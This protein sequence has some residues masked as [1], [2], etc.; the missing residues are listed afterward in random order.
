MCPQAR[1]SSVLLHGPL[2]SLRSHSAAALALA[3]AAGPPPG[4]HR[5]PH[6]GSMQQQQQQQQQHDFHAAAATVGASPTHEQQPDQDGAA[7]SAGSGSN[8]TGGL[9]R[10]AM[11]ALPVPPG[12]GS[13]EGEEGEEEAWEMRRDGWQDGSRLARSL[14]AGALSSSDHGNVDG[15]SCGGD[16]GG[17][18]GASSSSSGGG[19]AAADGGVASK[20]ARKP[21]VGPD[22]PDVRAL[23][24]KAGSSS[25]GS[26][27]SR[28]WAAA[29]APPLPS[30]SPSPS[31]IHTHNL[32]HLYHSSRAPGHPGPGRT[33]TS[34][35]SSSSGSGKEHIYGLEMSGPHMTWSVLAWAFA[36]SNFHQHRLYDRLALAVLLGLDDQGRSSTT[37]ITAALATS[38]SA[39]STGA[40]SAFSAGSAHGGG[41]HSNQSSDRPSRE[42]GQQQTPTAQASLTQVIRPQPVLTSPRMFEH[43]RPPPPPPPLPAAAPGT[44]ALRALSNP[45]LV[46]LLWAYAAHDHRPGALLQV[47]CR[48]VGGRH[49]AAACSAGAYRLRGRQSEL[50]DYGRSVGKGMPNYGCGIGGGAALSWQRRRT[51]YPCL[52]YVLLWRVCGSASVCCNRGEG[53]LCCVPGEHKQGSRQD[54][55]QP[56]IECT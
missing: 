19:G 12:W 41:H 17:E 36:R 22:T 50:P 7:A 8:V 53:S 20:P 15:G 14:A 31:P 48:G 44:A 18:S 13:Q 38:S 56:W 54:Q 6:Q 40:S 52:V 46:Q 28:L 3:G 25:G 55:P 23:A 30:S 45:C 2:S 32:S 33:S 39:S 16:G 34:S 37:T 49:V 51:G 27:S 4:G 11:R 21:A 29:A 42:A 1:A 47:R 26:S 43:A 24:S 10:D 9:S 5:T 35:G